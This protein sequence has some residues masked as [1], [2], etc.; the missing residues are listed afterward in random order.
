MPLSCDL[1]LNLF[2]PPFTA[3]SPEQNAY[4]ILGTPKTIF[5]MTSS[6]M[7]IHFFLKPTPRSK[8]EKPKK[9]LMSFTFIQYNMKLDTFFIILLLFNGPRIEY[10]VNIPKQYSDRAIKW[11]EKSIGDDLKYL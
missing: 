2:K 9:C 10:L 7:R 3:A 6:G 5:F 11:P 8:T 1:I 4:T